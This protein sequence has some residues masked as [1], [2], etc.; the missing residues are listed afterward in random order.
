MPI[1]TKETYP[2]IQYAI[3]VCTNGWVWHNL[4]TGEQLAFTDY[5]DLAKKM[6]EEFGMQ[7]YVF[8]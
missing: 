1:H 5:G 6:A 3:Q 4:Q 8:K 7:G 2:P